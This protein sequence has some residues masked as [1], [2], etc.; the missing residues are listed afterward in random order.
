MHLLRKELIKV[1]LLC[2]LPS[3]VCYSQNDQLNSSFPGVSAE[4][5]VSIGEKIGDYRKLVFEQSD[6][7]KE[8]IWT[9][10]TILRPT[11][12]SDDQHLSSFSTNSL[13]G[14][15][16]QYTFKS[17]WAIYP[18][19]A[20]KKE[21]EG[22][23][24]AT[25]IVE[26]DG[27]LT[28]VKLLNSVCPSI[29]AEALR[30]FTTTILTPCRIGD[31]PVRSRHRIAVFFDIVKF[32]GD[33]GGAITTSES[34]EVPAGIMRRYDF[35]TTWTRTSTR[36]RTDKYGG[37][38]TLSQKTEQWST[39]LDIDIPMNESNLEKTL[40]K[41]LY[42]FSG[43]SLE[44]TGA[45]FAKKFKGS[46][47]GKEYKGSSWKDVTINARCLGYKPDKYYSYG[48]EVQL[49]KSND[50]LTVAHNVLW[51]VQSKR[52]MTVADV[53]TPEVI[54]TLGITKKDKIDIGLNSHYLYIGKQGE[55]ITRIALTQS[56]WHKFAPTMQLLLG[57]KDELV[58]QDNGDALV[59]IGKLGIQPTSI[60]QKCVSFPTLAD[61]SS[62]FI[63]YMKSKIVL[64]ASVV[65]SG[66]LKVDISCMVEKDGS[67][68]NVKY[69]Q[70]KNVRELDSLL[71]QQFSTL[72][73]IKPLILSLDGPVRCYQNVKLAFNNQNELN[74]NSYVGG[75]VF[76]VVEQMPSFPGGPQALFEYL[77]KTIKYPPVAEEN[78][79]QG[80][81]V[82][83]FVV[84]RDG[85]IS[86]VKIVKSVDP[87]LDKEALRVTKSM[88][89]WIPGRQKGETV[90]VK[91]TVPVTFRLQ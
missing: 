29:D 51:D 32:R 67:L 26:R 41:L 27:R 66:G 4:T 24:E 75:K 69:T 60:I 55:R 81:V 18:K 58:A 52:L 23:V 19:D 40:C 3:T 11:W 90:R 72:S 5:V 85:T 43:K 1:F 8:T 68:S 59:E 74:D 45:T 50:R 80:R 63:E 62:L 91:Y 34:Y 47:S 9:D 25:C 20:L 37:R 44:A 31:K 87:S 10:C 13:F 65:P 16:P 42:G 73:T 76:D 86:D 88:P 28:D 78:G 83:S 38:E 7:T 82:V 53:L 70:N 71:N 89:R 2:W 79:V 12:R 36:V 17:D 49:K 35:S 21:I 56:N 57:G 61:G 39:S 22:K 14:R 48:Y 6:G 64:P 77:S 84:E 30:L 15:I 33:I 54:A 46:I